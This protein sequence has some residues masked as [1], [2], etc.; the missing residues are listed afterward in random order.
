MSEGVREGGRE[1]V[2][3]GKCVCALVDSEFL[4]GV[5]EYVGGRVRDHICTWCTGKFLVF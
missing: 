2:R 3:D 4:G 1:G 5:S